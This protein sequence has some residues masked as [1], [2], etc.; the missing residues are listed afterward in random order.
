MTRTARVPHPSVDQR[1]ARGREARDRT[2][3]PSHT[4]VMAADLAGRADTRA[5]TRASGTGY[6]E[7]MAGFATM[8]TMEVWYA[9][10]A[11]DDVARVLRA[12]APA[13]TRKGAKAAKQVGRTARRRRPRLGPGT[14][15]RP[16]PSSPSSARAATGPS[17]GRR[18]PFRPAIWK[19]PTASRPTRWS[20]CFVSSSAPTGPRC[21]TTATC[22]S[23][24]SRSTWPARCRDRQRRHPGLH[25][26]S[27][28][29]QPGR[30]AVP[31][32][33]GGHRLG[34]GGPPAGEQVPAPRA[35]GRLRAADAAG[36]QRHLPGL[37]RGQAPRHPPLLLAPAARHERLAR[38]RDHGADHA[39]LL[40]PRLRV[41]AR[42]GPRPLRD[43]IAIA[44]YLGR[45]DRFE[46]SITDFAERYA[47]QNERDHQA[48]VKA[49]RSGR[50]PA[51]EGV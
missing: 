18:S 45:R 26:P 41:D 13:K 36:R 48:F 37:D 30:P 20:A 35:A 33:Q 19:P 24:S 2:P 47:D 5:A 6:R 8:A 14:A 25:R 11:E 43:P 40:R 46:R 27:S 28:G 50:L 49:I 39:H 38:R 17:A 32:A 3:L 15:C 34:P 44:A 16:C 10:L 23:G 12:A 7:A 29:S 9:R 1:R 51:L 21:V 31:A 4:G 42:P 22:W